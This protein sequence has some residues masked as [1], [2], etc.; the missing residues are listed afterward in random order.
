MSHHIKRV[1]VLGAGFAGLELATT[2]AER[3]GDAVDVTVID[4]SDA[5]VFGFAKLDVLFG[6]A[7]ADAVRL[8]YR[9]FVKRGVTFRRETVRSIDPAARRV[10][11]DA[12]THETDALV[13]ALGADY[14]VS[15]TPGITLGK[16]EFYSLEGAVH[17]REVLPKFARGHAVVGVCTAPYKCPPAPSECALMLHDYLVE[18]G[19]RAACHITLVNPMSSPVPPSPETSKALLAAFA[20]RGIEYLPNSAVRSVD[21]ARNVVVVDGDRELPCDLFLGVPRNRA[22]DVVVA[23]GLTEG[24]WVP[25]NPRTL[26]TMFPYVYAV[27]DLANTGAPKAGVFAE[28]AARA[29]AR[30][31]SA[32]VEEREPNEKNPGAGSCYIEFGANRI[33]RVDVDFFSG[34]KPTGTFHEPSEALRADKKSFGSTRKARWFGRIAGE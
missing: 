20:E 5:F 15:T 4:K 32:L 10:V 28:G 12:G 11:T 23:A 18:R 21:E 8:P 17:L 19:V 6:K 22:P 13:I 25:V 34:P 2:L 31:L 7:S 14:D 24:D 27:G 26:E 29:V 1:L 9:D 30:N 3:H 16:N 33:A